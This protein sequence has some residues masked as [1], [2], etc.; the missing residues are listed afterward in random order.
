MK[1]ITTKRERLIKALSEAGL[2][3]LIA[4]SVVFF[5]YVFVKVP[6]IGAVKISSAVYNGFCIAWAT[7]TGIF[8]YLIYNR[9]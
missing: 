5:L 8:T 3:A 6:V 2:Y 9:E 4:T 7:L 1:V